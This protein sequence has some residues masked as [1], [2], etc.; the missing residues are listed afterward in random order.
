MS[1]RFYAIV[2]SAALSTVGGAAFAAPATLGALFQFVGTGASS[3][4]SGSIYDGDI[5][6]GVF[7]VANGTSSDS[8]VLQGGD[9]FGGDTGD[10]YEEA[11]AQGHVNISGFDIFTNYIGSTPTNQVGTVIAASPDTGFLTFKNSSGAEWTGNITLSGQAFG[12][13]YGPA[14]FFSN[15][16]LVDLHPGDSVNIV[17]NNE[18]SNYGGYN[19]PDALVPT[20]SSLLGGLGV[21]AVGLL[22]RRRKLHAD[23]RS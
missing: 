6:S 2:L 5:H 11:Q 9:P 21:G 20:P 17:L 10:A 12:G 7:G 16:A 22:M 19:H 3:G 14:Q 1:N 8:Y 13:I 4:I 15:T 23:R 18:S